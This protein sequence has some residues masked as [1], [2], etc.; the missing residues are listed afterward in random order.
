MIEKHEMTAIVVCVILS[1]SVYIGSTGFGYADFRP[2]RN[3]DIFAL[4]ISWAGL[5]L[6]MW[7]THRA[8]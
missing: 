3:F 6:H 1:L 8:K 7:R 2:L 4:V 5:G